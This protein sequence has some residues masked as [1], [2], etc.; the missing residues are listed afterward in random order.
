VV[1]SKQSRH[2][3]GYGAAWDKIRKRILARDAGLCQCDECKKLPVPLPAN[4]VD[5]IV[6]KA[7]ARR[8]GWT[9]EQI[10]DDSNLQSLH[11]DCHKRKTAAEQGRTLRPKVRISED[12]WPVR[13]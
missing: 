1:W 4:E 5:H 3:R 12:G 9:D 10:D 11:P 8:M 6:N 2:E 13:V 7:K